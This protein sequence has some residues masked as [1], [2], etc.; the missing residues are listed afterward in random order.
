MVSA[1]DTP[2]LANPSKRFVV[3]TLS[4]QLKKFEDLVSSN[5][6]PFF[7][8]ACLSSDFINNDLLEM[9]WDNYKIAGAAAC[10]LRVVNDITESSVELMNEPSTVHT[11]NEEPKEYLLFVA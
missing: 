6:R 8:I 1:L 7:D 10:C 9:G 5:T 11:K 4:I 2:G 3:D